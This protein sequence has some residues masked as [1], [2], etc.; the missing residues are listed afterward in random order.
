MCNND[1]KRPRNR[2]YMPP[3]VESPLIFLR[4]KQKFANIHRAPCRSIFNNGSCACVCVGG[5]VLNF[6]KEEVRP[7]VM[8]GTSTCP[9]PSPRHPP[10][11][12]CRVT[13]SFCFFH[14]PEKAS[15][16]ASACFVHF[17]PPLLL[18]GNQAA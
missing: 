4:S 14:S 16:Q 7:A 5:S 17:Y 12:V 10:S 8:H 11:Y 6:R 15:T 3:S 2:S 13:E 9:E 18:S 1:F